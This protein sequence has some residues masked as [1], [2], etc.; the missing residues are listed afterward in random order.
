MNRFHAMQARHE[1]GFSLLELLV[2]VA[3]MMVIVGSALGAVNFYQRNYVKTQSLTDMH[4]G[5]RGAVELMTHE[6]SQA[7]LINSLDAVAANI[8]A[9]LSVSQTGNP[10]AQTV[11]VNNSSIFYSGEEV[12]VDTGNNQETVVVA[13]VVD[14]THISGIFTR[15]HATGAPVYAIGTIAEGIVPPSNPGT[16]DPA[17]CCDTL[18][19]IGDVNADGNLQFVEYKCD[20][21]YVDSSG[22]TVPTLTRSMTQI[23]AAAKNAAVPLM[24]GIIKNPIPS[25]GTQATPCFNF[26]LQNLSITKT[27][28]VT[29]SYWY[30]TNISLTLTVQTMQRDPQTNQFLTMTKSF[31]DLSPRNVNGAFQ[32]AQTSQS[33]RILARPTGSPSWLP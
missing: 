15:N 25:G 23:S 32:L 27:N 6:I 10:V 21:N 33:G 1:S 5:V 26:K 11:T 19:I 18:Q 13:S 22:A 24:K 30:T 7:G 17:A 2:S 16:Y 31:L 8:D 12:Q 9:T 29:L 4:S 14:S 3:V 20:W 28:G